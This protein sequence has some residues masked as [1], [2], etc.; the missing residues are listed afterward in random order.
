[1]NGWRDIALMAMGGLCTVYGMM[2]WNM[3]NQFHDHRVEVAGTYVSQ[4]YFS[5][6]FDR[7][8]N[9]IDKLVNFDK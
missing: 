9:K 5:K 2:F 4:T 6:R 8:E 1:M 7:L 3:Y